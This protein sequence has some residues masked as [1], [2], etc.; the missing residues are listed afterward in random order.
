[1]GWVWEWVGEG[2]GAEPLPPVVLPP[3]AWAYFLVHVPS[4]AVLTCLL[5]TV[6]PPFSPLLPRNTR[7]YILAPGSQAMRIQVQACLPQLPS[8]NLF[9]G[10]KGADT[11]SNFPP[12]RCLPRSLPLPAASDVPAP[13]PAPPQP[14]PCVHTASLSAPPAAS[15]PAPRL[16]APLRPP[17]F[18]RRRC[19]MRGIEV[20]GKRKLE[21]QKYPV[22]TYLNASQPLSP[23]S[24]H[25]LSRPSPFPASPIPILVPF[26]V[27][28]ALRRCPRR[29]VAADNT[30]FCEEFSI[31]PVP[32]P[33]P[34][35]PGCAAAAV[36]C[37]LTPSSPACL[38]IHG[39]NSR[40][41]SILATYPTNRPPLIIL[42]R[43]C[44]PAHCSPCRP[45]RH[46]MSVRRCTIRLHRPVY[47]DR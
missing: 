28:H 33:F 29:V 12:A 39:V 7:W 37:H 10:W 14:P 18:A 25:P 21:G 34:P 27:H 1:M 44:S 6:S 22:R 43:S 16:S 46:S 40:G 20:N 11:F 19:A 38:D 13:Q 4:H 30:E 32:I 3:L 24:P 36:V 15:V 5:A 23:P 31:G 2:E 47:E 35:P 8:R 9:R 17:P 42:L 26:H 41:V 45:R